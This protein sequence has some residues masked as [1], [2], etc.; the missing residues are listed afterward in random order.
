M[1]IMIEKVNC[2]QRRRDAEKIAIIGLFCILQSFSIHSQADYPL[3]RNGDL[4]FQGENYAA[5]ETQYRKALEEIQKP[6]SNYNLGNSIYEQNRMQ[7]AA[8][9]YKKAIAGTSDPQLKSNA[10]FN[11]GN[12]YYQQKDFGESIKAYKESLKLQPN[13]AEAKKN[14]MLAMRQLQQQQQQQQQQEQNE[15]QQN[16]DQQD[17]QDKQD[18]QQQQQ[19]QKQQQ[20]QQPKD[21][22]GNEKDNVSKDEARE[23]LK[24]IE[25]EDQRVQEKLK[26]VS[27]T[28]AAPVK[29]W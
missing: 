11:L 22:P 1:K 24:A 26:K 29:D 21:S 18:Q 2:T 4:L 16:K 19:Q 3:L 13:D 10:W 28:K 27:G 20:Q 14:L 23:I 25:R 9:S 5:A 7:E 6:T 8:E 15:Q 17:Q 12:S